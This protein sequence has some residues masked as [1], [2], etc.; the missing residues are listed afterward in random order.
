MEEKQVAARTRLTARVILDG[1]K[2]VS[3]SI[4]LS[5]WVIL[6]YTCVNSND[7]LPILLLS[8]IGAVMIK[9]V[10]VIR[11][12]VPSLDLGLSTRHVDIIHLLERR[13]LCMTVEQLPALLFFNKCF[14]Q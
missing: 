9:M 12:S 1:A 10:V 13:T 6:P 11:I 8:S 2:V 4:L 14:A 5:N 3:K 7:R